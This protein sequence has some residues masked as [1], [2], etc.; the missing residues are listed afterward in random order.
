MTCV[1]FYLEQIRKL[2]ADFRQIGCA[3]GS[4]MSVFV[5]D[6]YGRKN[7][8]I[9]GGTVMII[10]TAILTSST[11]VAQLLVGR[12]VTG[13]GNGFNSSNIPAYQSE[14]CDAKTRGMLLCLQGVVTIVGLCIA[15]WYVWFRSLSRFH[16]LTL[17]TIP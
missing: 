5:A 1:T 14:H 8:I 12:I 15:Y 4:L 16:I 3:V 10:G 11:T 7:M 2:D 9:A 6:R 13:I 17:L